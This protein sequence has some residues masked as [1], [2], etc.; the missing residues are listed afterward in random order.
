[1]F[2]SRN[3]MHAVCMLAFVLAAAWLP[4]TLGGSAGTVSEPVSAAVPRK[5]SMRKLL[6]INVP[7]SWQRQSNTLRAQAATSQVLAAAHWKASSWL[8]QKGGSPGTC[9]SRTP[10][11][12]RPRRACC[13]HPHHAP[14][15]P[16]LYTVEEPAQAGTCSPT[17]LQQPHPCLSHCPA[18]QSIEEAVNNGGGVANTM[19]AGRTGSATAWAAGQRDDIFNVVDFAAS[20]SSGRVWGK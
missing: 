5:F 10:L 20:P 15:S 6:Q 9:S 14:L 8:A 13:P 3:R 19:R 11:A 4:G 16:A 7:T 12:G 1:M 18:V 2:N 17:A